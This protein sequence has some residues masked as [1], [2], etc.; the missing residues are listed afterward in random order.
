[1]ATRVTIQE[2]I[3]SDERTRCTVDLP[4]GRRVHSSRDE[5]VTVGELV[6]GCGNPLVAE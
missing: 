3:G 2:I 6:C 1:M 5:Q 4:R